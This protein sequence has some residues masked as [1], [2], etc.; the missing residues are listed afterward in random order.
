M[1]LIIFFFLLLLKGRLNR[2][3]Q[4]TLSVLTKAYFTLPTKNVQEWLII[5][6]YDVLRNYLLESWKQLPNA[7]NEDYEERITEE[8]ITLRVPKKR[9]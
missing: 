5:N 6:N 7:N 8:Q 1:Y 4:R 3:R 9:K 2:I